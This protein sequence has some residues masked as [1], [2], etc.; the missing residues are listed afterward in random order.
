MESPSHGRG[1]RPT[2]KLWRRGGVERGVFSNR[3]ISLNFESLRFIAP[4]LAD[5]GALAELSLLSTP[6]KCVSECRVIVEQLALHVCDGLNVEITR[7]SMLRDLLDE[8]VLV[9]SV[10]SDVR[11]DI[12]KVNVEANIAAYKKTVFKSLA[13]KIL[14]TTFRVVNWFVQQFLEMEIPDSEFQV[15]MPPGYESKTVNFDLDVLFGEEDPIAKILRLD[16]IVEVIEP[17]P[18]PEASHSTDDILPEWMRQSAN[19]PL[20]DL[21][22]MLRRRSLRKSVG[23]KWRN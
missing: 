6:T 8:P 21:N 4:D 18:D 7:E 11:A 3:M 10:P 9:K 5:A 23:R 13:L 22:S 17:K 19:D 2:R 16:A 12:E 15:P 14:R 1:R 20:V